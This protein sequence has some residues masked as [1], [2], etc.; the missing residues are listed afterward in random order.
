[1]LFVINTSSR[2]MLGSFLVFATLRSGVPWGRDCFGLI[3]IQWLFL[4][5]TTGIMYRAIYEARL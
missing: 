2:S 4:I 5:E 1:M 3:L